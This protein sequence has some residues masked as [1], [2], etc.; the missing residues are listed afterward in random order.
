MSNGIEWSC[1]E[2]HEKKHRAQRATFQPPRKLFMDFHG[3]LLEN[4]EGEEGLS[5]RCAVL[6]TIKANVL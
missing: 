4:T 5:I 1:C 6:D 3:Y 2:R